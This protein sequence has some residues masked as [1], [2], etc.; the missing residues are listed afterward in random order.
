M[1]LSIFSYWDQFYVNANYLCTIDE[2]VWGKSRK[3]KEKTRL[4]DKAFFHWAKIIIALDPA[5]RKLQID[6]YKDYIA[7]Y[8]NDNMKILLR[9]FLMIFISENFK[10]ALF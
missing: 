7:R 5:I 4:L 9:L 6:D 3:L 1:W 8:E 2:V 10:F